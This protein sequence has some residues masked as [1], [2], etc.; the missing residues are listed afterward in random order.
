MPNDFKDPELIVCRDERHA[1]FVRRQIRRQSHI[2]VIGS[3]PARFSDLCGVAPQRI[4]ICEG[5]DLYRDVDGE[6]DLGLLLRRRQ[7]I[8]GDQAIFIQL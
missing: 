2:R 4:T 3:N 1:R 7:A 5:V 6:G 8:W